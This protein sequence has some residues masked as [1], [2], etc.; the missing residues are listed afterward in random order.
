MTI[1][2]DT[3]MT[4]AYTINYSDGSCRLSSS[5]EDFECALDCLR[6]YV[7]CDFKHI[8]SIEEHLISHTIYKPS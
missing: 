1:T 2:P 4:I 5:H 6:D 7:E 3:H 8:V